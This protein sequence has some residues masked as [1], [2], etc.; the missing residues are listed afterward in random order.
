MAPHHDD[1]EQPPARPVVLPHDRVHTLPVNRNNY[2]FIIINNLLF[3]YYKY[4]CQYSSA[5][6]C[7][8]PPPTSFL[9]SHTITIQDHNFIGP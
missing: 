5:R 8:P 9:L 1:S 3:D 7:L 4:W 2:L 6:L